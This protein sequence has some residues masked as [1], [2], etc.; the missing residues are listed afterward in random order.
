MKLINV[1]SRRGITNL[2]ADFILK[3]IGQNTNTIIQVTDCFYYFSVNGETETEKIL[4]THEIAKE[5]KESYKELI[6]EK[7]INTIDLIKYN[8]NPVVATE[9]WFTFF[10]SERRFYHPKSIELY[11]KFPNIDKINFFDFDKIELSEYCVL[12]EYDDVFDVSSLQ[13]S[14]EFPYGF[15][16]KNGRMMLYYSEY[17]CNQIIKITQTNKI[18][19]KF[20]TEVLDDEFNISVNTNKMYSDEDV[21]STILDN[22]DFDLSNLENS[23]SEYDIMND[24]LYPLSDK[25]WIK[26]DKIRDLII[27]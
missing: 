5:F 19:F 2:L 22:F 23:I 17:L 18:H 9:R 26:N 24:L 8:Q 14:S 7:S 16:L 10:N 12:D 15:G 21:K 20:S 4:D 13:V 6:G 3:K 25:P 27:F 11:N 1:K